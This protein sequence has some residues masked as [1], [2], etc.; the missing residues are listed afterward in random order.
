MLLG[1][2]TVRED[3]G[4]GAGVTAKLCSKKM[5]P[6]VILRHAICYSWRMGAGVGEHRQFAKSRGDATVAINCPR[7]E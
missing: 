4:G 3:I 7:R 1:I 2:Y 6:H 5:T